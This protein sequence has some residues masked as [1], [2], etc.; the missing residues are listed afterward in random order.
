M[1]IISNEKLDDYC[2]RNRPIPPLIRRQLYAPA[3][4]TG[5]Q[6]G[7]PTTFRDIG[8]KAP[9]F[10]L[11]YAQEFFEPDKVRENL[12]L[13]VYNA[14]RMLPKSRQLATDRAATFLQ[15][16]VSYQLGLMRG[17][18][19]RARAAEVVARE[20]GAVFRAKRTRLNNLADLG[21]DRINEALNELYIEE[22]II[23]AIAEQE[24]QREV[25]ARVLGDAM[26]AV[27]LREEGLEQI[28]IAERDEANRKA[29]ADYLVESVITEEGSAVALEGAEEVG[30]EQEPE[31]KIEPEPEESPNMPPPSPR[32]EEPGAGE[33]KINPQDEI[34]KLEEENERLNQEK[35]KFNKL[36]MGTDKDIQT[37]RVR[38]E[39]LRRDLPRKS[40]ERRPQFEA[41]IEE[42]EEG[43]RRLEVNLAQ[44]KEEER[45]IEAEIETNRETIEEYR[46]DL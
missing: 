44:Y 19:E 8:N 9:A 27:R 23:S 41:Q 35:A 34:K 6:Q 38:V 13:Q 16:A 20:L 30:K 15:R 24:G 31:P 21:V 42:G 5:F 36:A 2:Y 37:V 29:V 14:I 40:A 1:R 11:K 25:F 43:I 18:R 46:K 7:T 26:D 4:L 32:P 3:T 12:G 33:E 10:E 39:G 45:K 28:R 17:R 22:L